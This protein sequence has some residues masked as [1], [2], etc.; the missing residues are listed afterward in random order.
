[1]KS[2]RDG[3]TRDLHFIESWGDVSH[4]RHHQEGNLKDRFAQKIKAL[5]KGI[6]PSRAL[7]VGHPR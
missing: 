5:K 4:E 6:V 3:I 1:M 2:K 7:Q